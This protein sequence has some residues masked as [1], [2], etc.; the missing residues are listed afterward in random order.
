MC[1]A[2]LGIREVTIHRIQNANADADKS[3]DDRANAVVPFTEQ[4]RRANGGRT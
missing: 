1:L 4:G 2:L 3:N